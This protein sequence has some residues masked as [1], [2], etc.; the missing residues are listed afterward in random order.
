MIRSLDHIVIACSDIEAST[1]DHSRLFGVAPAWRSRSPEDGTV[2]TLFALSNMSV[3]LLAPDGDGPV[4]DSLRSIISDTGEGM[5]SLVFASDDLEEDHRL[6]TRRGL[7]PEPMQPGSS[8][9]E[10][11]GRSRQWRRTRLDKA[12]VN[13]MR[14]FV[15]ET[16]PDSQ[17]KFQPGP[18]GAADALDHVVIQTASPDRAAAIYGARLGLHL[19]LDRTRKEWGTR[20]LFFPLGGAV[21]EIIC[22]LDE[23]PDPDSPD[24]LWGLTWRTKDMDAAHAR[25]SEAGFSLSEIRQGRKP[26]TRVFTV[27]DAPCGVPTLF[28]EQSPKEG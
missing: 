11:T 19:A 18:D 3:E 22:R 9:D 17:L 4:G 6:F 5:T 2:S 16:P 23:E 7:F 15:L 21:L 8:T 12:Q 25:L 27:R 20:F 13:G 10:L 24:R 1:A 26:G 28:L 14:L